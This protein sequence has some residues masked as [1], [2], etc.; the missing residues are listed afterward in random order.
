[1]LNL[2]NFASFKK[3]IFLSIAFG[4]LIFISL[5]FY[6]DFNNILESFQIFKWQYLPILLIL[7]FLN[8]FLRFLKWHYYLAQI[9]IKLSKKESFAVF[10]SGL[11]MSVT[12]GKVGELIKSYLV[13]ELKS[14]PI[15]Y[16]APIV[17]TERF[18]D[19]IAVIIL[20]VYGVGLFRYGNDALIISTL[21]VLSFLFVISYYPLFLKVIRLLHNLPFVSKVSYK[22]EISYQCTHRL[23][24][25]K[26]LIL[27]T[28]ISVAAWFCECYAFCLVFKGL[29]ISH[30]LPHCTFVYAFST[31]IGAL[32]MLPGGLGATEGS[33][34]GLL[35]MLKIPK[36]SAVAATLIIRV[37][38]LWFA[39][40]VGF[41]ALILGRKMFIK[42]Q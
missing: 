30:S 13:K 22:I 34:T 25:P 26:P 31:L 14:T 29:N 1:V 28:V 39:V 2:E 33:M 6:G 37:C 12:P 41:L 15:S 42:K 11:T 5:S 35:I 36:H 21:F 16:S 10:M 38:T 7:A 32:S 24:A 40:F 17:V 18:T 20:S 9:E 23:M 4:V 8:Y 19:F 27:T 3:K